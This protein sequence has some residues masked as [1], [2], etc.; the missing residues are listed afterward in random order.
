M[1]TID[2]WNK[3]Q[4]INELNRMRNQIHI[5][6]MHQSTK[7]LFLDHLWSMWMDNK[8]NPEIAIHTFKSFLDDTINDVNKLRNNI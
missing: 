2:Q 1:N 3:T 6:D 4:C 7:Q 8:D 5:S